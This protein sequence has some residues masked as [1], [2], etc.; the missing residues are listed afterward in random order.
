L[1]PHFVGHGTLLRL[2]TNLVLTPKLFTQFGY[3]PHRYRSCLRIGVREMN[4]LRAAGALRQSG[5]EHV[6]KLSH[7]VAADVD[8]WLD[9]N[10]H[11]VLARPVAA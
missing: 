4:D 6:G 5:H 8:A 2:A 9:L 3:L 7:T 1:L 10:E 11:I